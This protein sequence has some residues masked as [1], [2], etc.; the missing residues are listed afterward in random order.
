[1]HQGA[2]KLRRVSRALDFSM[3]EEVCGRVQYNPHLW[4]NEKSEV[5][6]GGDTESQHGGFWKGK[7]FGDATNADM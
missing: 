3:Q 5:T 4:G 7:A 2:S 1:M 6:K